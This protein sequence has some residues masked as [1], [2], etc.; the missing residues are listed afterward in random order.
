MS[1]FDLVLPRHAAQAAVP[2]LA[3]TACVGLGVVVEIGTSGPLV[4]GIHLDSTYGIIAFVL[5]RGLRA[6]LA[7]VPML[8]GSAMGAGAAR[9]LDRTDR[10][11]HGRSGAGRWARRTV[12][13]LVTVGL[14]AFSVAIIQPATTAAIPGADGTPLAGSI[15]ELTRVEIGGHDL[16]ML[17]RGRSVDNP[18]LLFLAGGPGGTELGAMRRHGQALEQDFTVV[19]LDQR[20][21]GKSYDTLTRPRPSR[22]IAR[23]ATRAGRSPRHRGLPTPH[24]ESDPVISRSHGELW[25]DDMTITPPA[26]WQIQ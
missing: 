2:T 26:S 11:A 10:A 4:D 8:L 19:T 12:A 20:G 21:T 5:G 15:A 7:V 24:R 13:G 16:S 1:L 9:R 25:A 14:V 3:C 17:I 6:L 22:S 23:S 18:V